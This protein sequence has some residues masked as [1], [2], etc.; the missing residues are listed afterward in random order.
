L[1]VITL[2]VRLAYPPLTAPA[3]V[4]VGAMTMQNIVRIDWRDHTEFIPA[5][6][7]LIGIPLSIPSP[8]V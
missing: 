7:T 2:R 6:L 3:L 5:F 8:K 4:I 1:P